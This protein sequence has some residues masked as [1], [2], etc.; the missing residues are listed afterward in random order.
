MAR[1]RMYFSVEKAVLALGLRQTPVE[2]VLREA[3][4]WFVVHGYA[5]ATPTYRT[6]VP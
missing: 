4:D 6:P 1:K 2:Q 5:P 3:V